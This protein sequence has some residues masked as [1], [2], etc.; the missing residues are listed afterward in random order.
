MKKETGLEYLWL[1]LYAFGG[2]GLEVLLAFVLEPMLYG[3]QMGEWTV[4][5]NILHWIF[6]CVLWG[7]VGVW[8]IIYA[9]RKFQFDLLAKGNSMKAW[10]WLAV[11]F[12]VALSL[13]I[14]YIDWNGSKVIREFYANGWLKFIFQYIYYV[15]ETFLIMLIL[16]FGQRA[17]ELWFHNDKIPY[18]GII[19]AITWGIAHFFTKDIVTGILCMIS[20]F[21]FG[22]VYLL[23]NRDVRKAFPI[24]FIMFAL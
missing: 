7:T 16:I 13:V 17:F 23:V 11:I 24:L 15:F 1:A 6:T 9:K 21:A 14:S 22:S 18:G 19:V 4:L 3:A 5:Q 12:F 20:G 10:Q 8:L 2:I